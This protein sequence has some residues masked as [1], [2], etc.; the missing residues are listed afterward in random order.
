MIVALPTF[1][2]QNA[3]RW[4]RYLMAGT[5]IPMPIRP[6]FA[7]GLTFASTCACRNAWM[8]RPCQTWVAIRGTAFVL[9]KLAS[10]A[11]TGTFCF[12][13]CFSTGVVAFG[14]SG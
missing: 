9:P 14:S 5:G 2:A 11:I 3:S 8:S 13:A 10:I 1:F 12:C 6:S 4:F 7:S